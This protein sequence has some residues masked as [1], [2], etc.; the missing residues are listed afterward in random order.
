MPSLSGSTYIIMYN[1][2]VPIFFWKAVLISFT[3]SWTPTM[4]AS[5]GSTSSSICT[6]HISS[7]GSVLSVPGGLIV[8]RNGSFFLSSSSVQPFRFSSPSSS[9]PSSPPSCEFCCCSS[10][11]CLSCLQASRRSLRFFCSA[12]IFSWT[13]LAA[14]REDSS[15]LELSDV[16]FEV[17]LYF[18]ESGSLLEGLVLRLWEW[19]DLVPLSAF[20]S[21]FLCVDSCRDHTD[22]NNEY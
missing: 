14:S 21:L 15:F 8:H 11:F 3:S 2:T 5:R 18:L 6:L 19:L 7:L 20:L 9:S 13:A 12:S 22:I 1:R 4:K 17:L 16:S 10:S